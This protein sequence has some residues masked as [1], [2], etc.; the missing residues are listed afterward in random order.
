[1][2]LP[3]CALIA[4]LLSF[5][6]PSNFFFIPPTFHF[7][8]FFPPVHLSI[9][10]PPLPATERL[11]CPTDTTR[12]THPPKTTS[13]SESHQSPQS[14]RQAGSQPVL[15]SARQPALLRLKITVVPVVELLSS[16]DT[17]QRSISGC[18]ALYWRT[19]VIALAERLHEKEFRPTFSI[20]TEH[21]YS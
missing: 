7:Y 3:L 5:I 13:N 17:H 14:A 10:C 15:H 2:W 20:Q 21:V 6:L 12:C 16:S 19:T 4:S 8:P 18:T 11:P 9:H 1:M